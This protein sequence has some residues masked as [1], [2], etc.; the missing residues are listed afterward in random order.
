MINSRGASS[1]LEVSKLSTSQPIFEHVFPISYMSK[2]TFFTDQ[3]L[4]TSA[5][6]IPK[7]PL[8]SFFLFKAKEHEKLKIEDP[9]MK[10]DGIKGYMAFGKTCGEKWRKLSEAEKQV[11]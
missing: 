7:K 11:N 6:N 3:T 2:A 10:F 4:E 5:T 8:T 9:N 1:L